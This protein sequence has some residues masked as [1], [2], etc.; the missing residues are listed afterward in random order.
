MKTIDCLGDICPVPV[1]KIKA[2]MD[3]IKHGEPYMIV[4]DH[5]C[6]FVNIKSFCE[7][8]K[9][10]CKSEEVINGVWEITISPIS[11]SK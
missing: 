3:E 4:T 2:V 10:E 5:S 8:H 6:S 9:L 7:T 1:L 11:S